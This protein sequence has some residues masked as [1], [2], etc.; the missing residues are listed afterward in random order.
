MGHVFNILVT[1]SGS[2]CLIS[3]REKRLRLPGLSIWSSMYCGNTQ[4]LYT[5][6]KCAALSLLYIS[7]DT[8]IPT[9]AILKGKHY[10]GWLLLQF[11]YKLDMLSQLI[12]YTSE[13][14]KGPTFNTS[15]NKTQIS[16]GYSRVD[17]PTTLQFA[18]LKP[19][20]LE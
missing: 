17:R 5:L 14:P 13:G 12:N 3:W 18:D 6:V 8:Y 19:Y 7:L 9:V 20:W 16:K 11:S 2:I 10:C 1:F 4:I 15:H